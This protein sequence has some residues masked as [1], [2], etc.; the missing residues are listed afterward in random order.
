MSRL[1][2]ILLAVL[3]AV[4]ALPTAALAA[5]T[6]GIGAWTDLTGSSTS[7]ATTMRLPANGFPA[8]SVTST[9]RAGQV[10]P[11]SGTSTW[12][13]EGSPVGLEYGS[14]RQQPYLNL[15]PR[16]DTVT[17]P[18]IT[19]YT[20][21]SATPQGWAFV[22]GDIDADQV[23]VSATTV[24][25][26]SA[27][28]SELG[29]QTE[30]NLC[31]SSPRP[32]GCSTSQAK[33][34]PTWDPA[35]QT[36]TGNDGADDT[37][38]AA[39]WFEPTVSLRALTLTFTRRSGFPVFQTWF[40]VKKQDL[41]GTVAV[42]DGTCDQ[43]GITV[44]LLDRQGQVVADTATTA[45]GAYEFPGVAASDG[46]DVEISDV[47]EACIAAGPTRQ[48]VDLGTGAD[49]DD[50]D[51]A[52]REI[53]PVPISGHVT[54]D[55]GSPV[56]GVDVTIDG[57]G[58]PRT[59]TTDSTGSYLFD[60][61]AVGDYTL[62][63]DAPSG[64]SGDPDPQSVS[65]DAGDTEPIVDRDFVIEALPS[66]S[67]TVID[68]GGGLGGATVVLLD[69]G[70]DEVARTV[71]AADG[72][73]AFPRLPLGDYSVTIPDPPGDHLVPDPLSV[74]VDD[75]VANADLA[76]ARPGSISGQVV[77]DDTAEPVAGAEITLDGGGAATVTTDDEGNYVFDE[78]DPGTYAVTVDPPDGRTVV[79]QDT[80]DVTIDPL[81]EDVGS[82]DFALEVVP[83]DDG[84]GDGDGDGSAGGGSGNA[85]AD[86][87]LP[88]TG[89]PSSALPLA[90]LA[91]IGAGAL[92]LT[93]ARVRRPE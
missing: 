61:N 80:R 19:T 72:A 83:D 39:G 18:S 14:S 73:Y 35:T 36:L 29:F 58:G 30:F 28:A 60:T 70:G 2:T 89:A 46:Y 25:G 69:D 87:R 45:G 34:E 48:S 37:Y 71:T 9:S 78:L 24:D 76:L 85:G 44:S 20:F 51:F 62:T 6:T 50:A 84:D 17:A 59:T 88:D 40:A 82:V 7:Y 66:L 38:G 13:G 4:L 49:V 41:S 67:G 92:V 10:G 8:A 52:I 90:G 31:D 11:Q 86:D 81:G 12:F 55:D 15:R 21:A 68:G 43:T 79:G 1:S 65:I 5:T 57:P 74:T 64:Y 54:D 42:T 63:V 27:T 56:S 26:T 33:D 22:L 93:G 3:V 16:A 91:L 32:P 53:I 77:D 23:R 75:D 47:P